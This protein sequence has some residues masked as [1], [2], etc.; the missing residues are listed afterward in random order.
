VRNYEPDDLGLTPI[1]TE[2]IKV[3]FSL[4]EIASVLFVASCF[5]TLGLILYFYGT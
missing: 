1:E 3:T 4:V 5:F 2:E